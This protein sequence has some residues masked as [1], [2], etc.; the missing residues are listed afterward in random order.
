M[1]VIIDLMLLRKL[2]KIKES[3]LNVT[4][5]NSINNQ[6][7]MSDSNKREIRVGFMIIIN[8]MIMIATRIPEIIFF[9][10]EIG[11]FK[12]DIFDA[13][14]SSKNIAEFGEFIFALNGFF[15]FFIFYNFNLKFKEGFKMILTQKIK[16]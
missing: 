15:Q 12:S 10:I 8:T 6:K 16:Y 2:L 3:K 4:Q 1:I 14:G 5:S 9:L 11:L 13:T 7:T